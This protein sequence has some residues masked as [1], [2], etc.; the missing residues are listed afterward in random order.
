MRPGRPGKDDRLGH[1]GQGELLGQGR[2]RGEG[3]THPG[4]HLTGDLF[5][6]QDLQL[7]LDGAEQGRVAGVDPDHPSAVPV[8]R[9]E[10]GADLRQVEF[11]G[12]DKLGRGVG[13][14]QHRRRHQGPGVEHQVRPGQG[15]LPL[16]RDELRVA[17]PGPHKDDGMVLLHAMFLFLK[18]S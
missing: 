11:S 1:L 5:P 10:P 3:R 13:P 12:V 17:G 8:S 2:G 15:L 18:K 16:D 14:P 6:L 9:Q 4:N 7:L